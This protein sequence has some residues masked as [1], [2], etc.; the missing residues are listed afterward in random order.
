MQ[1]ERHYQPIYDIAESAESKIAL[2]L[3]W[4]DDV[5][6]ADWTKLHSLKKKVKAAREELAKIQDGS[7]QRSPAD[8]VVAFFKRTQQD[9][10]DMLAGFDVQFGELRRKAAEAFA[11]DN[12]QQEEEEDYSP[13]IGR[14]MEE[15]WQAL[16]R[17]E[18][19]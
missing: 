11:E 10:Q 18:E 17:H 4:L 8:P 3:S 7:H 13:F 15:V 1:I 5:S 12:G 2:P 14:G 6:P 16:G 19:L 9:V